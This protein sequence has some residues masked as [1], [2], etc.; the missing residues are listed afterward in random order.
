MILTPRMIGLRR[1]A[2]AESHRFPEIAQTFAR[3][4]RGCSHAALAAEF[5]RCV[6]AGLLHGD[7]EDAA[8]AFL[9]LVVIGPVDR[10]MFDPAPVTGGAREAQIAEGVRIFLA[11]FGT[12]PGE[13]TPE[14]GRPGPRAD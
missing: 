7:P 1:L 6:R 2:I 13:G 11:A 3:G 10:A 9:L 12:A 14:P 5:A 4:G 8:A